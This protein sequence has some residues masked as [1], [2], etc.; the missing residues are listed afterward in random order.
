MK[1]IDKLCLSAFF[2]F[3]KKGQSKA[4]LSLFSIFV[5]TLK[6]I[7]KRIGV[8]VGFIVINKFLFY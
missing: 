2:I 3:A 6:G 4:L 7:A 1:K 5:K 8:L